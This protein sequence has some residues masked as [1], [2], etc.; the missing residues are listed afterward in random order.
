MQPLLLLSFCTFIF[1]TVYT[2]VCRDLFRKMGLFDHPDAERKIHKEPIPRVGGLVMALA[3]GS[4]YVLTL[5]LRGWIKAVPGLDLA[6]KVLPGAVVVFLVGLLDD[7]IALKPWQKFLGQ[8]IGAG[9]AY[10]AGL[11]VSGVAGIS[12]GHWLALPLTIFWLVLCTNAFNLIDGVDGL[13]TGVGLFATLTMVLAAFLQHNLALAAVTLPLAGFLLGFLRYNFNPATAFLGD[14]GSLLIGFLLGCYGVIWSD[15]SATLLGMTA[16]L[17]AM[18]VPLLDVVLSVVRRFLRHQPIFDA[19]RGHIHHRLL[20]RGLTPRGAVLAL[21]CACT[22]GALFSIAQTFAAQQYAGIIVLMFCAATWIGIQHLGYVEFGL[23]SRM[24]LT[25]SFQKMLDAQ[26]QLR[27]FEQALC[28]AATVDECWERLIQGCERFG[29]CAVRVH[30]HGRV[31]EHDLDPE[32]ERPCWTVSIPLPDG[33]EAELSRAFEESGE[34]FA[35]VPVVKMLREH[36]PRTLAVLQPEPL[37]RRA[38][39][40]QTGD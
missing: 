16:P 36:L 30:F 11:Q 28:D 25:G 39:V 40:S 8:L 15:K 22:L 31:W 4:T 29:F 7:W 17:M 35:I 18:F 10:G 37:K 19:D 9:W 2:P 5:F 13:A 12:A 3:L 23:A 27:H 1:A 6:W 26:I 20:D 38:V 34:G 33:G 21:Y 14:S 32:A 24:L